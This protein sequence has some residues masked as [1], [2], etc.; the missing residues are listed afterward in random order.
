MVKKHSGI[1]MKAPLPQGLTR[2]SET[3][4]QAYIYRNHLRPYIYWLHK[5][6]IRGEIT[7]RGIQPPGCQGFK[8]I[9]DTSC[10][11]TYVPYE[12]MTP[13]IWFLHLNIWRPNLWLQIDTRTS[14]LRHVCL[15]RTKSSSS[16]HSF[17]NGSLHEPLEHNRAVGIWT[18]TWLWT[19]LRIFQKVNSKKR[20]SDV[21]PEIEPILRNH[22]QLL[23]F[24]HW[25]SNTSN[26]NKIFHLNF[27]QKSKRI[28]SKILDAQK[29]NSNKKLNS[30]FFR[31][32]NLTESKEFRIT[33][34]NFSP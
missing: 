4:R 28:H 18:T 30:G 32:G 33:E 5:Q 6:V 9:W 29:M 19:K 20:D 23:H 7:A 8:H 25:K 1:K 31:P 13:S 10:R 3:V 27:F 26:S 15:L 14:I 11:H 16:S 34:N 24:A 17:H 12:H 2:A 21:S 22:Q